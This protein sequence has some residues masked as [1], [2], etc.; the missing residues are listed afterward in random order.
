MLIAADY[1]FMDVFWSMLIFFLWF[2]WLLVLFRIFADVFR[3]HD[4]SGWGKALWCVFVIFLPF[5]G[6][7]VYLIAE[8]K[9]MGRRDIEQ[10]AAARAEFD[11]Y[12]REVASQP[13]PAPA[14]TGQSAA[15]PPPTS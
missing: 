2:A 7:F 3:R 4:I 14:P 15:P 8:G 9:D 11:A 10:H 1:P 5:L 13:A 12:V 6:V